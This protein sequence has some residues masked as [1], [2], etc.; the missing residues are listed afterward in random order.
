MVLCNLFMSFGLSIF[1][2]AK[3]YKQQNQIRLKACQLFVDMYSQTPRVDRIP[4][5]LLICCTTSL[6]YDLLISSFSL[7]AQTFGHWHSVKL[8]RYLKVIKSLIPEYMKWHMSLVQY[9]TASQCYKMCSNFR[10]HY[11]NVSFVENVYNLYNIVK[12]CEAALKLVP[13]H[14][15]SFTAIYRTLS[16]SQQWPW[17]EFRTIFCFFWDS[18]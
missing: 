14:I 1:Q 7:K 17:I 5:T 8:F 15:C 6:T 12:E 3:E 4:L 2:L 11:G 18:I 10:P 13:G 16:A 9:F